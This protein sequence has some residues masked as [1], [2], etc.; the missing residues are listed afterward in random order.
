M[1]ERVRIAGVQFSPLWVAQLA[2][3][4]KGAGQHVVAV[5]K[6]P[7]DAE[8]ARAGGRRCPPPRAVSRHGFLGPLGHRA[9]AAAADGL[10]GREHAATR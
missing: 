4:V 5:L 9:T 1:L 6:A 10:G 7:L 8:A 2:R 3:M